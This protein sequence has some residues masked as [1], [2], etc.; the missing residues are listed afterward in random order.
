MSSTTP[1]TPA[2]A[3]S[4]A[5]AA[6]PASAFELQVSPSWIWPV[7]VKQP[8]EGSFREER[9]RARFQLAPEE[10]RLAFGYATD[11][12]RAELVRQLLDVALDEIFDVVDAEKRPIGLTPEIKA[13]MIRNPW[14]CA[15][16]LNA[17]AES[18]AGAPS[19]AARGN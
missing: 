12:E 17:Y 5:P 1:S 14:I 9:F 18:T 10:L 4:T 19:P 8:V 7:I 3:E 2:P 11:I 15:G 13:A 6:T 16:L